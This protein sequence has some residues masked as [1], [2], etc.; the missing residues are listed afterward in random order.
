MLTIST[1]KAL[2]TQHAD[3]ALVLVAIFVDGE[4]KVYEVVDWDLQGEHLQL[5]VEPDRRYKWGHRPS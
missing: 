1:L 2:V 3:D 4:G 5:N